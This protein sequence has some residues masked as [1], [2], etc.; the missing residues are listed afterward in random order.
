MRKV[1]EYALSGIAMTNSFPSKR[2]GYR[3]SWDIQSDTITNL[4]IP[5][6]GINTLMDFL[7][8][9]KLFGCKIYYL[10]SGKLML[11]SDI[12]LI[13]LIICCLKYCESIKDSISILYDLAH[14][15][16]KYLFYALLAKAVFY[17]IQH[18]IP[19]YAQFI[20]SLKKLWHSA[21]QDI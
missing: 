16:I 10:Y 1:Q 20:K 15:L 8:K 11:L 2:E 19:R 14:D 9:G 17:D 5:S 18:W 7:K 4:V 13:I 21:N 3:S 12:V 6:E